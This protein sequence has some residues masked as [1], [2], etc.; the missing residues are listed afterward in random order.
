VSVPMS[1]ATIFDETWNYENTDNLKLRRNEINKDL[2]DM[3]TKEILKII[4]ENDIPKDRKHT[5]NNFIFIVKRNDFFV[6]DLPHV[7]KFKSQELIL[8]RV[9][10][11]SSIM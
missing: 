10:L 5:E 8:M 7:I 1:E 2:N 11:L 6:G 9:L 3:T 4:N